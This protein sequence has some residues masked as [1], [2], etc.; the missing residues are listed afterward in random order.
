MQVMNLW[1]LHG[2][3]ILNQKMNSREV[4]N[5]NNLLMIG[6]TYCLLFIVGAP[7]RRSTKSSA[8]S[9]I[10]SAAEESRKL[11]EDYNSSNSTV[12]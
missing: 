9:I 12:G 11:V 1:T 7:R 5:E 3:R 6:F 2:P 8:S 4:K 10:A